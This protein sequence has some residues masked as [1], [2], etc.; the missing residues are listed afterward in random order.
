MRESEFEFIRTLIYERSR[1]SLGADKRELV[2]ARVAKRVRAVQVA[3]FAAYCRLLQSPGSEEEFIHL[4]DIISTH[5]TAFF[6]ENGHFQF[7][8]ERVVPEMLARARNEAWPCFRAWSA[9]CSSGEE[10]YSLAITLKEAMHGRT[11]PWHI[12]ATDIS[13][14]VVDEASAGIYGAEALRPVPAS[15]RRAHFQRGIG[16][17]EGKFRVKAALRDAVSFRPFNLFSAALP[18]SG[19]FQVILCR[20]VMIY[21]DR[22]SQQELVTRLARQLVPGGYL[23]VGHAES[24]NG[25]DHLL[26]M[27]QP[28]VYRQPLA[29]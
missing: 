13:H 24:L 16:P 19:L 1:I 14:R 5:H 12:E 4:I 29:A 28:A 20:N 21:F 26:Q 15:H 17:Q 2:A 22:A 8:R 18:F 3:S 23:L 27:V 6:R 11:W 9:A 10:P 25:I 7:I